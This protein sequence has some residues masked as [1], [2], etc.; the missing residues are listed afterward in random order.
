MQ[1]SKAII[2]F[3]PSQEKLFASEEEEIHVPMKPS[4]SKINFTLESLP[5]MATQMLV[6]VS[7]FPPRGKTLKCDFIGM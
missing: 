5:A 4:S 1:I 3:F 2:I 6:N 7:F